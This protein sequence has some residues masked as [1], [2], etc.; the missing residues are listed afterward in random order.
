MST[1]LRTQFVASYLALAAMTACTGGTGNTSAP[2]GGSGNPSAP[3][4]GSGNLAAPS[5]KVSLCHH[6]GNG[7]YQ[8]IDVD[9]NAEPAH[10]AHGDAKVGEPVPG[11][12]EA[13]IRREPQASRTGGGD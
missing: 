1:A 13:S 5:G 11:T 8:L 3:S 4:G 9:V 10:R 6:T 2:A 7:E 12:A